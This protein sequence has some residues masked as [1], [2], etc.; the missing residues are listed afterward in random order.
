MTAAQA[1]ADARAQIGSVHAALSSLEG[2]A[3]E[4]LRFQ[5]LYQRAS[6]MWGKYSTDEARPDEACCPH[7]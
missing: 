5:Q 7:W 3:P 4:S 2:L 1:R 6:A